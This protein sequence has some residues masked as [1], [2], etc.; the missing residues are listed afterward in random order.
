MINK[1]TQKKEQ[2]EKKDINV[3]DIQEGKVKEEVIINFFK[4]ILKQIGA[5]DPKNLVLLYEDKS[6]KGDMYVPLFIYEMNEPKSI[7]YSLEVLKNLIMRKLFVI[8]MPKG[9]ERNE[10]ETGQE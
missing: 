1:K 7:I 5:V 2:V 9:E 10:Q 4:D 6:K 8:Q 3:N